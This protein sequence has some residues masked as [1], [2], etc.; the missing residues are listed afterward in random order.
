MANLAIKGHPTRGNEVIT[1]LEMLGGINEQ[2]CDG[3]NS[4]LWYSIDGL[5]KIT[6]FTHTFNPEDN[7]FF[8]LEEFLEKFPYKIG[9][10]VIYENK[11]RKITKMV[12]EEQTNT[13]A[14]KLDDKMYCNVLNELQPYKEKTLEAT[15]EFYNK[16][17]V[18]CGS[19]RCTRN[20]EWLEGCEHYKE[21]TMD[22][23]YNVEEYL[24]VWEE[25]EKGLEVVVNDKFELKEDN[26]KFYIIKKQLQFPKTY[27][28]CHKLMVQW[29]EY[30]CNPNSELILCESPIHDFCKIIVARNIYWKIAGD[31]KYDVNK[32]E[33]Y[34]YIVN[35]CGRI[36]KEHYMNF[37][38]ILAFPTEEMRD[39]FY[40]NFKD[41]IERC[42]ELL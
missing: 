7:K 20:G 24:K 11:M 22:R 9:D 3:T 40:E 17:C 25:T 23:K 28:E 33:E 21:E 42:K 16:Y 15:E 4:C 29:K 18:N 10:K 5:N 12:W 30:D 6:F 19:Q 34:F 13:V 26:G 14:Y 36:V 38:H 8:T 27:G 32:T 37:N 41:L 35:K 31:W 39:A 1:L 2:E